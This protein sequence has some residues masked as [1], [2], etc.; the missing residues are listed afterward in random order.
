LEDSNAKV[1]KEDIF[2]PKIGNDSLHEV[3]NDKGVRVI[4][5]VTSKNMSKVQRSHIVTPT[6]FLGHFLMEQLTIKLT[7]FL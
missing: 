6:N 2:K 5:F 3:S 4:N 7:I 1:G